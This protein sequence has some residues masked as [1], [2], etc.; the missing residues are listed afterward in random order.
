[1]DVTHAGGCLCGAVRYRARSIFDA[2]YCHCSIC[3][4]I[5]G[6]PVLAWAAVPVQDF[7][8]LCGTPRQYA[9]SPTGRRFFC[10]DCGTQLWFAYAEGAR[11]VSVAITTLDRPEEVEPRVHIW[12][13]DRLPWFNTRDD[14]PRFPNGRLPH[15]DKRNPS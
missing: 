4:R 7:E 3:Q 11:F 15:P 13:P 2:G 14:L 12:A 5:H 6:A 8:V 10:Q 1:M 9:S